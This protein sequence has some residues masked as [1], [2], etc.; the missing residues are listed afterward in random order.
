MDSMWCCLARPRPAWLVVV[1][2]VTYVE[3]DVGAALVDAGYAT[4][5][6]R[7]YRWDEARDDE[8][9]IIPAGGTGLMASAGTVQMPQVQIQI[10]SA[11]GG[12]ASIL[13]TKSEMWAIIRLFHNSQ[14]I[15][16]IVQCVWDTREPD[17]WL[18]DNGRGIFS[19]EFTVTKRV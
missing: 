16:N 19:A 2:C 13:A 15:T 7:Y 12:S 3:A 1:V 8:I 11:D 4:A 10:R 17:F 14:D 18:D 6:I 9:L 5:R